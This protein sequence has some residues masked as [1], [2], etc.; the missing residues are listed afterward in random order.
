MP[1]SADASPS[2]ESAAASPWQ[3]GLSK[4][5]ESTVEALHLGENVSLSS[6]LLLQWRSLTGFKMMK[7]NYHEVS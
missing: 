6:V 5:G 3:A 4:N 7:W 2:W 1:H